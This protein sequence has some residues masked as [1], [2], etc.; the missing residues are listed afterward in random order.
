M[1]SISFLTAL[2]MTNFFSLI[3]PQIA[4]QQVC[5]NKSENSTNYSMAKKQNFAM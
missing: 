1:E 4:S 2:I 3:R 5:Y